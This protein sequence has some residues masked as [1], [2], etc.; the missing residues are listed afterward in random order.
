MAVIQNFESYSQSVTPIDRFFHGFLASMMLAPMVHIAHSL[1]NYG[2]VIQTIF[3]LVCVTA[4]ADS[5]TIRANKTPKPCA[6]KSAEDRYVQ[7]HIEYESVLCS[8]QGGSEQAATP[9]IVA[10]ILESQ[11]PFEEKTCIRFN[12]SSVTAHCDSSTD[13]YGYLHL[14]GPKQ[15]RY[16]L[17]QFCD[18]WT[19]N[20]PSPK[21]GVALFLTGFSSGDTAIGTAFVQGACSATRPCAWVDGLQKETITHELGHSFNAPHTGGPDVM[22]ARFSHD[23]Q[24]YFAPSSAKIISSFADSPRCG[25]RTDG[26]A[27]LANSTDDE[28]FGDDG[29]FISFFNRRFL[30]ILG[31]ILALIVIISV[32]NWI[33]RTTKRR[34]CDGL[35]DAM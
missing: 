3:I 19:R 34:F 2:R 5:Q 22:A 33:V 35:A 9:R 28:G 11:Q 1:I 21:F 26:S 17:N 32:V 16:I 20:N 23:T 27:T 14:S 15:S 30:I 13:P 6:W 25:F 24:F 7:L 4:V 29:I 8:Q 31:A 12:V 18:R 10:T